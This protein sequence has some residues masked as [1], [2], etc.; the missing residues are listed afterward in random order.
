MKPTFSWK[1]KNQH[2]VIV[3]QDYLSTLLAFRPE[4]SREKV[5][6]FILDS[7]QYLSSYPDVREAGICPVEHY[8]TYGE[9]EGR[10]FYAPK[11]TERS[12]THQL[13]NGK[14][15]YISDLPVSNGT[16][17]YRVMFRMMNEPE[18]LNTP[19]NSKMTDLIAA[20]F[21]AN[22][23]IFVRPVNSDRNF[24]LFSLC[25]FLNV[26]ITFDIDDLMLPEYTDEKGGIRSGMA[27]YNAMRT[28]LVVNSAALIF[29]DELTCTT[30]KIIDTY[31]PI[32]KNCTIIKNKLPKNY[33][34]N[35]LK[36]KTKNPATKLNI[37]Y[38]SGTKTHLKDFSIISGVLTRLA[39]R[40]PEKFE[41]NFMGEIKD[42][43]HLFRSLKISSR[44][45]PYE[46]FQ[47]MLNIIG[48]H[49]LILVPLE[50]SEFN[51][52]KSN[53]KFIEAASQGVAVIASRAAEFVNTIDNGK[54]GWLCEDEQEWYDKIECLIADPNMAIQAGINAHKK[55]LEFYSL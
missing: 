42:Q 26:K 44:C 40:Y 51:N 8:F 34:I 49:H 33:F 48:E 19:Y 43:S 14:K 21:S 25:R 53:I 52:A 15:V 41:I 24:Y 35:D 12:T 11:I 36:E 9:K 39:Q 3:E 17:L 45:I 29:A 6:E 31:T 20:I 10:I 7:R 32:I 16:F 38:L 50:K 37:L 55:S 46:S 28:D 18:S 30:Q 1:N 2:E 13:I 27:D 23:V 5:K 54:D 4:L 47:T 22:E